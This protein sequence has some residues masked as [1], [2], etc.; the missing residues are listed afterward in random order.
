MLYRYIII[1]CIPISGLCGKGRD[2][3]EKRQGKEGA[4]ESENDTFLEL[5]VTLENSDHGE[6]G[7]RCRRVRTDINILYFY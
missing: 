2:Y 7:L 6:H 3:S 5:F 4:D 1:V